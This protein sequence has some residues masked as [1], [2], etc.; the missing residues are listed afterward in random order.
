[1]QVASMIIT[2]AMVPQ[3]NHTMQRVLLC[4]TTLWLAFAAAYERSRPL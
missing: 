4:P 3:G 1:M 2:R